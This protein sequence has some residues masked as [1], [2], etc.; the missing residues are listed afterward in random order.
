ML[1]TTISKSAVYFNGGLSNTMEGIVIVLF[2]QCFIMSPFSFLLVWLN[3]TVV[4]GLSASVAACDRD[5]ILV[6]VNLKRN[7]LG[8]PF[9]VFHGIVLADFLVNHQQY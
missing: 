4:N 9:R 7:Q 6:T 8:V 2:Y 3:S 1:H 5:L